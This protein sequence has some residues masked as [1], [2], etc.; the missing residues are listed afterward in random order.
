MGGKYKQTHVDK[1]TLSKY[2]DGLSWYSNFAIKKDKYK[3]IRLYVGYK[4]IDNHEDYTVYIRTVELENNDIV[5][6]LL[7]EYDNKP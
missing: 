1:D 6:R 2:L 3:Y 5:N 7:A 4:N